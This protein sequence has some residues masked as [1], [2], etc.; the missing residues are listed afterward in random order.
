MAAPVM[1]ID[2]HIHTTASDGTM[3][4]AELVRYAKGKGLRT[5]AITDPAETRH[6]SKRARV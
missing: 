1:E 5:I 3:S 4:P 6:D 2:L